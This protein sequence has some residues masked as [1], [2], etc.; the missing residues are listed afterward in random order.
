MWRSK[1]QICI[2]AIFK[3]LNSISRNINIHTFHTQRVLFPALHYLNHIGTKVTVSAYS[4]SKG[5]WLR[6][7][8]KYM[9]KNTNNLQL[10]GF[11]ACNSA[12]NPSFQNLTSNCCTGQKAFFVRF[13][14]DG[15]FPQLQAKMSWGCRSLLF[16]H[17]NYQ[18]SLTFIRI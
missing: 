6:I 14:K 2:S 15:L 7:P 9:R 8:D 4:P 18:V 17:H 1:F 16:W 5:M 13:W 11:Q 3:I 12:N 10:L